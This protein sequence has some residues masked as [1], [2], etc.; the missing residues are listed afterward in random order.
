MAKPKRQYTMSPEALEQRQM[1]AKAG[2][3]A[4]A[5]ARKT[6][7]QNKMA[8]KLDIIVDSMTPEEIADA[9]FRDRSTAAGIFY[10]KL[11]RDNHALPHTAI[12]VNIQTMGMDPTTIEP[13]KL[14][15]E[16]TKLTGADDGQLP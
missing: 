12:Q 3:E 6:A 2:G 1:V 4:S 8:E 16:S 7:I 14:E 11:Y 15:I 5:L 10:D 9:S 13:L